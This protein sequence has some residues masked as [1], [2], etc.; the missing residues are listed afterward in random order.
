MRTNYFTFF[1]FSM[2]WWA[3]CQANTGPWN[4]VLWTIFWERWEEVSVKWSEVS[5]STDPAD[6]VVTT[7]RYGASA[8]EGKF[9]GVSPF[10][11]QGSSATA[12]DLKC[13]PFYFYGCLVT[14]LSLYALWI[15]NCR[16]ISVKNNWCFNVLEQFRRHSGRG[17]G[18]TVH[19]A[20]HM[21]PFDAKETEKKRKKGRF[22]KTVVEPDKLTLLVKV[23]HSA[24]C[25]APGTQKYS[26]PLSDVR[27]AGVGFRCTN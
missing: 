16:T 10:W 26:S 8:R 15:L 18:F 20:C 1:T 4:V 19:W 27:L 5:C 14:H 23:N 24:V 6:C 11:P 13:C 12:L 25:L 2:Y 3:V 21:I 9:K 7:Q 17:E 22:H